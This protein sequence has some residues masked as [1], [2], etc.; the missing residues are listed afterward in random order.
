MIALL[1]MIFT[2]QTSCCEVS[3]IPWD[4]VIM[5]YLWI[6]FKISAIGLVLT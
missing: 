4:L 3:D 2:I 6:K 1:I 5:E